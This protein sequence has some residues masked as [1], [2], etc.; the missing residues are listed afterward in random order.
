MVEGSWRW[1]VA[2]VLLAHGVGHVLGVLPLFGA[3]VEGPWHNRS[4][5]LAG[6]SAEAVGRW[7]AP[8]LWLVAVA[9]FVLVGLGLL[10]VGVQGTPWRTLA[11]GAALVSAVAIVLFWNGFPTIVNKVGALAVDGALLWW[12]LRVPPPVAG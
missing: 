4:W 11:M 5:M 3:S 7:L 10:G 12:L 8:V 6:G 1:V 2:V 9:A